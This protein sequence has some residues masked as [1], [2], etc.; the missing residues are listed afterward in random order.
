MFHPHTKKHNINSLEM[1]LTNLLPTG[2]SFSNP[3]FKRSFT[4]GLFLATKDIMHHIVLVS[5][6][7]LKAHT[8]Q[9]VIKISADHE[10]DNI[11]TKCQAFQRLVNFN[12]P[13]PYTT[14][15][16]ALQITIHPSI[17]GIVLVE[18]WIG[19]LIFCEISR[20]NL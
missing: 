7:I 8:F 3:E 9:L 20:N 4:I 15:L 13:F 14:Y 5:H 12:T 16:C 2:D 11:A 1:R 10:A 18:M 19:L 17:D 6:S